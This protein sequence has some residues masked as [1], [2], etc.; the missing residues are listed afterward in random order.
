MLHFAVWPRL[1]SRLEHRLVSGSLL[2]AVQLLDFAP[3][4]LAAHA[5]LSGGR[6]DALCSCCEAQLAPCLD[7]RL[8]REG[9]GIQ[10]L[11]LHIG[12]QHTRSVLEELLSSG[13]D[14]DGEAEALTGAL[15]SMMV[16][17][18]W[19]ARSRPA[20]SPEK[21]P[22]ITSTRRL[23][24]RAQGIHR[25]PETTSRL[26][27]CKAQHRAGLEAFAKNSRALQTINAI[28]RL[29]EPLGRFLWSTQGYTSGTGACGAESN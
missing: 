4:E 26:S 21:L 16:T 12:A 8:Q 6:E 14:G 15:A 20:A 29:F 18:K 1:P 5:G 10:V 24:G 2:V 23:D 19:L 22:P 27:M 7:D 9:Q 13:T 25:I 3:D 17:R 28:K 11:R